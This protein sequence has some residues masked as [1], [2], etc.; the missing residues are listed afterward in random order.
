MTETLRYMWSDINR[1]F[2]GGMG[3]EYNYGESEKCGEEPTSF[4]RDR[5]SVSRMER[6]SAELPD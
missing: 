4:D 1:R 2:I 3:S 6:Y 5:S